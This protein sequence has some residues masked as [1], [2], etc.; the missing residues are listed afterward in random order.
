LQSDLGIN[1]LKKKTVF[2]LLKLMADTDEKC[3]RKN[4][5]SMNVSG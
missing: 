3:K 5:W 2:L 4:D 1:L